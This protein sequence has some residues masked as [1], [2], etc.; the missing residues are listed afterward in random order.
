MDK[1]VVQLIPAWTQLVKV[2]LPRNW[3]NNDNRYAW[4]TA[5][6]DDATIYSDALQSSHVLY[7][8]ASLIPT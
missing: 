3:N 2:K 6:V 4:F 1:W 8:S 7:R 5:C